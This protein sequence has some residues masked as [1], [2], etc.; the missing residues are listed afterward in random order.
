[1]ANEYLAESFLIS[2][3]QDTGVIPSA[4]SGLTARL[5]GFMNREQRVYLTRLLLSVRE[6]YRVATVDVTLVAGTTSYPIPSRAVGAKLKLVELLDAQGS[7]TRPLNPIDS[8][9]VYES[10]LRGG[11]G[12]FKLQ[13]NS[14]VFLASPTGGTMR[15]HYFRRLSRLVSADSAMEITSFSAGAKTVTGTIGTGPALSNFTSTAHYDL[16]RGAPHFDVLG[17]DLSATISGSTLT[18]ATALP[19]DLA[20]GDF[21]AL[22]GQSPI[23]NAPLELHDVLAQRALVSY[24][25]SQGDP[26]AQVAGKTLDRMRE[27]ALAILSPRV[28]DTPT[29]LINYNGPGWLRSSRRFSR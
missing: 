16:I 14:I 12:D 15:L 26:K 8:S 18:F 5:F 24:L 17:A 1:M 13:D 4:E 6:S 25:E 3:M 28:E 27:D 7:P 29:K 2:A 19:S 10:G 11:P 20:V 22:A 21:V 9:Q 23:C